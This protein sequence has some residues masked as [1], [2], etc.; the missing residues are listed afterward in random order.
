MSD[1]TPRQTEILRLI[2]RAI[3]ET[4]MPPHARGD[5]Q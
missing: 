2:Q 5:R 3:N 1:L 4:G